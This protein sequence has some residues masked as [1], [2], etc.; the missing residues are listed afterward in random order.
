MSNIRVQRKNHAFLR[1]DADPNAI[2]DLREHFQYKADG[3]RFVPAYKKGHWDGTI[4]LINQ[5]QEIYS[6]L[7]DQ[8]VEFANA[9][10]KYAVEQVD[11]DFGY[12]KEED[13]IPLERILSFTES[14]NVHSKGSP[15]QYRDYQHTAISEAL[16]HKQRLLIS[17][18]ASGKSL[19]IYTI[20]RW[21][22]EETDGT[23]VVIVPTT[24]LVRQMKGD[25]EDY[26]SADED[27]NADDHCHMVYSG[28][29][30]TTS[31]Q[32]IITTWQSLITFPR[33]FFAGV[34]GIIGDEAHAFKAKSLI[35]I[36]E[37][38]VN[39]KWRIGTTGT[40]DNSKVNKTTLQG[41][42]GPIFNVTK[43]KT[44]MDNGTISGLSITAI[45]YTY[46]EEIRK[47]MTKTK[48]HD[49]ITF[50]NEFGHRNEMIAK[51]ATGFDGNTIIMFK[52]L[53]HGKALESIIKGMVHTNRKVFFVS[54]EEKTD[55]REEV[56]KIIEEEE[57]AILIASL[58]VFS[59]GINIR[60]IHNIIFAAP[61]KSHIKILQ[62]IGRGL[63]KADNGRICNLIDIIDDIHWRKRNNF[64]LKH[65]SERIK[66]YASE[67]FEY[68]IVN[69]EGRTQ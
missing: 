21:I 52:H 60:N 7:Y 8:I 3:Y 55:Y 31:K 64:A 61:T 11:S 30:K 62:S 45:H 32:I 24:S 12:P 51:L 22:Q 36:M 35:K 6:G 26:S 23:L 20:L 67:G 66:L 14:L 18:T 37:A 1:L 28:E 40:L 10:G 25:F 15:I 39:A 16:T 33:S 57:D 63:R 54:G 27:W 65:G 9:S 49:E 29:E 68:R 59:T 34:A 19:I 46:P 44:L 2:H 5:R 13:E 41:L 48:Y 69:I 43:T 50:I 56:R 38:S 58:G 42:F 53:S 47:S 17:P 4:H